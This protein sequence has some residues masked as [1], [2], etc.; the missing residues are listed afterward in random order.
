MLKF[1]CMASE[2][3]LVPN[4]LLHK[5]EMVQRNVRSLNYKEDGVTPSNEKSFNVYCTYAWI[6]AD[7]IVVKNKYDNQIPIAVMDYKPKY[8]R[9]TQ[10]IFEEPVWQWIEEMRTNEE[11]K[12]ISRNIDRINTI[13]KS[14]AHI[15]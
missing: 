1:V 13:F 6:E 9:R 3:K 4:N 5:S 8:S 12:W 2:H 7:E 11:Q 10:F 15:D 14:F